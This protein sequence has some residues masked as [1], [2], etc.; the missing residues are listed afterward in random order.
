MAVYEAEQ[1]VV[2]GLSR[3]L[4]DNLQAEF[5]RL[6]LAYPAPDEVNG[7]GDEITIRTRDNA[8][9][10]IVWTDSVS[11]I[12]HAK[13]APITMGPGSH[14]IFYEMFMG[15]IAY[16]FS[17]RQERMGKHKRVAGEAI[18]RILYGHIYREVPTCHKLLLYTDYRFS[19]DRMDG[20]SRKGLK[21]KMSEPGHLKDTMVIGVQLE[22]RLN[23]LKVGPGVN[24]G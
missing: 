12:H 14:G 1:N 5:T 16:T 3:I 11:T 20:G 6:G 18:R 21:G 7:Y 23:L 22:Y 13:Q 4:K 15:G 10:I 19:S 8:S 2:E 24:F 9:Q 17:E